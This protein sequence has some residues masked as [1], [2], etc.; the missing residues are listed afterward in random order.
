MAKKVTKKKETEEEWVEGPHG[1]DAMEYDY[2]VYNVSADTYS[3][4]ISAIDGIS[5]ENLAFDGAGRLGLEGLPRKRGGK[6]TAQLRTPA[7]K[8]RKASWNV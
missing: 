4:L 7:G 6:W 2:C 1:R 3:E 8:G 5:E